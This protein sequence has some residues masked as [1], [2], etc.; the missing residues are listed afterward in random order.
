MDVDLDYQITAIVELTG[1]SEVLHN[2]RL[3]IHSFISG[4]SDVVW[5]VAWNPT[6]PLLA[7][8]S[9]DKTVRL[10]N[11][12][13]PPALKFTTAATIATEHARTVRAIAWAPSG[14]T[15]ATASFD[16]NIGIW[17]RAAEG[18]EEEGQG[19]QGEWECVS[20]LE[21]HET[22]CK[23][24]A[25]SC[26]GTLLASC[27]RDKTV[28]IWEGKS[29]IYG[30]ILSYILTV[31]LVQP[32]AEFECLG[33]LMHHTQDV[34]YVAWHPKEEVGCLFLLASNNVILY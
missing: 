23:G 9:A 21:G 13:Q 15:L 29:F 19:P 4:H 20:T 16:A 34:K 30:S 14:E 1:I 33:V 26:T 12:S 8:C 10:F 3:L 7:S 18:D 17:E 6:K 2:T 32:E 22:E 31:P 5:N 25:Y 27:S 11:Y 24:V 28:W